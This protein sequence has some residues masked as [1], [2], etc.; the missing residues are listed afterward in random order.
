MDEHV[1]GS[2]RRPLLAAAAIVAGTTVLLWG[3]GRVA[4]C[5]GGDWS[6][7]SWDIWSA[8]NSQHLLDPYAFT[9]VLHGIFEYWMIGLVFRDRSLAWR[10]VLAIAIESTWEVVENSAF[11][12]E[13]YRAVTISLD[14]FGDSIANSLADIACC[15][16]GV[17]LAHALRFWRSLGV[18]VATELV[19]L[20]SIRDSLVLNLVMLIWPV[21]ALRSWQLA[22]R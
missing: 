15:A 2:Q 10:C 9:H 6:P 11:V 20:A 17:W 21:D 13:R 12:I 1:L 19:L 4:W 3:Q 5:R 14:Y 16:L 8:H 7:W 18:F 22:G